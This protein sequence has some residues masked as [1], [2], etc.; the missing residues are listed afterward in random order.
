MKKKRY[1]QDKERTIL[2]AMIVSDDVLDSI[3]RNL[4]GEKRPFQSKWTNL[5]ANWCLD[6]WSKYQHAPKAAIQ[7]LFRNWAEGNRDEEIV[8]LVEKFLSGLS[9]EYDGLGDETNTPFII[10]QAAEHFQRI[11]LERIAKKIETSLEVK[12]LDAAKEAYATEILSFGKGAWL[13]IED[14]A[15]ND[16]AEEEEMVEALVQFPGELGDFIGN[17][18]QRDGFIAFA[19]PE[20]RGKS[21][22]LQEVAYLALKQRRR[23]LYYIVG[24]MSGD[25]VRR[26]LINRI[27]RRTKRGGELVIPTRIKKGRND[28]VRVSKKT[29]EQKPRTHKQRNAAIEELKQKT[30]AKKLRLLIKA[31]DAGSTSVAD[32]RS[33][34]TDL[35]KKDWVPDVVVI[36]YADI[37]APEAD[38]R[39]LE[40]RHQINSTW[41]ALR[42]L[43]QKF[44]CCVVTATQTAATSYD[45][46]VIR[47]TDFSEDKRKG[48]HVTG[49]LGINQT[50]EE[51]REGIYRLNWVFLRDGYWTDTQTVT[52]AGSLAIGC[53]CIVSSLLFSE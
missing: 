52:T 37:L 40:F 18:F 19:G 33:D 12:D 43:S 9:D 45:S 50:S 49:M 15:A 11:Q 34:I 14:A 41:I 31:A 2:T 26:R 27:T 7:D 39:H 23:V 5:V 8:E 1:A 51:K 22:W 25:Q 13:D 28:Q 38:A 6:H 48:A 16:R 36:D 29:V 3:S 53:P 4:K 47:K 21:F 10:D 35:V 42:A 30:A 44:H 17:N 20:K 24:D 46:K 32:I